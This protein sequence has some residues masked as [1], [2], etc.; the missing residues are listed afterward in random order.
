[1]SPARRGVTEQAA[2]AAIDQACRLLRLPTIR[3]RFAELADAA[4]RQQLTYRG[5]GQFGEAVADGRQPQQ[6]A[7]LVDGRVSGLL[8]D[9]TASRAHE[10]LLGVSGLVS[11]WS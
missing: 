4:K 7:G 2:D 8:G 1:M 6:A 3:D 5:F 9:T 10:R 11:S